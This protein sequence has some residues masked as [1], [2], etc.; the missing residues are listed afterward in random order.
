MLALLNNNLKMAELLIA[1][2]ANC[3]AECLI[4]SEA[5]TPLSYYIARAD[6]E[7]V[8]WLLDHGAD[9]NCLAESGYNTFPF[10]EE[11]PEC[12]GYTPLFRKFLRAVK[13][14]LQRKRRLLI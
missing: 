5:H 13:E 11:C 3:C 1:N 9:L 10:D 12:E 4:E 14:L 8:K 7:R 2:D 6:T